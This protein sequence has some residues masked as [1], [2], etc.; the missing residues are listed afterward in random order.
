MQR[1]CSSVSRRN[2]IHPRL[3]N[4]THELISIDIF[5]HLSTYLTI[6]LSIYMYLHT[7]VL[8]RTCSSVS[9]QNSIHSRLTN[10]TYL[11]ISICLFICLSIHTYIYISISISKYIYIAAY[12]LV[13]ISSELHP[14]SFDELYIYINIYPFIYPYIYPYIYLYLYL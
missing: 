6:N 5:I 12:M 10:Y 3:T 4:Y 13:R 14:S 2:S 7:Y 8:Q 11:L 9:R 1:T